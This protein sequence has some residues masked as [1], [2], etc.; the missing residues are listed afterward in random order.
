MP[1]L[2]SIKRLTSLYSGSKSIYMLLYSY[3]LL[4]FD[5]KN[6]TLR[7]FVSLNVGSKT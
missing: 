2:T 7:H 3:S 1:F 4:M 5:S 6:R